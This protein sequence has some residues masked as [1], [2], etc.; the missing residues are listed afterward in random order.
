ML[1]VLIGMLGACVRAR[2][3]VDARA[4]AVG[5]FIVYLTAAA[6][7]RP[8]PVYLTGPHRGRCRLSWQR[9]FRSDIVI[10]Q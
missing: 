6:T 4:G 3:V 7:C 9:W 5:A 10:I 1:L 2:P 8:N